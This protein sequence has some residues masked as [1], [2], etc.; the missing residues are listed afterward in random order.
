MQF[1]ISAHNKNAKNL[2]LATF[3]TDYSFH[4]IERSL[5]YQKIVGFNSGHFDVVDF[6][7]T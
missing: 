4:C 5:I 7:K 2:L 1:T 3:K 6:C